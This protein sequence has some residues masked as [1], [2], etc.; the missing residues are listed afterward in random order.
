M[1][2]V[3]DVDGAEAFVRLPPLASVLHEADKVSLGFVFALHHGR[4]FIS[5][6]PPFSYSGLP[7]FIHR[8]SLE[9]KSVT[10]GAKLRVFR[11]MP[12][13]RDFVQLP[14]LGKV[15]GQPF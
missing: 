13:R 6:P 12:I 14:L 15:P 5:M 9:A 10:D 7:Q 11:V 3:A 8:G 4:K 2:W 1:R